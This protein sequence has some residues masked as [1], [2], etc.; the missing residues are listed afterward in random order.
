MIRELKQEPFSSNCV[1]VVAAMACGC[2]PNDFKDRFKHDA[3]YSDAEFFIFMVELGYGVVLGFENIKNFD[4]K[5]QTIK[6]EL[7]LEDYKAYVVV[8]SE[9]NPELTH[10]VLWDGKRLYDPSPFS[11]NGKQFSDYEVLKIL[12]F[13]KQPIE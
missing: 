12:P 9:I 13:T 2:L 8:K 4:P 11:E 5:K 3:P 1:A 10:A 6:M 7:D